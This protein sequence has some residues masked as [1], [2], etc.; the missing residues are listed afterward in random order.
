[1]LLI[2]GAFSLFEI[3]IPPF[4]QEPLPIKKEQAGWMLRKSPQ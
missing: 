3:R 4:S 1:M 2:L